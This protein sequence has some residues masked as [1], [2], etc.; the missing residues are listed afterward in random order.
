MGVDK[1]GIC[2]RWMSLYGDIHVAR[3]RA[4]ATGRLGSGTIVMTVYLLVTTEGMQNL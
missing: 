2:T 4:T 3:P 1:G